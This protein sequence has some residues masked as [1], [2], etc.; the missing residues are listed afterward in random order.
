MG[1]YVKE[2][3]Q[4]QPLPPAFLPAKSLRREPQMTD[5]TPTTEIEDDPHLLT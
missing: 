2:R 4:T 1:S 3:E 5:A